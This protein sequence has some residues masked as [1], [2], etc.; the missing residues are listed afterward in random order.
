M[1]EAVNVREGAT[2]YRMKACDISQGGLKVE[3]DTPL[4]SGSHVVV[5]H[6][7]DRAATRRGAMDRRT[8]DGD[9][10]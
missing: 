7:G 4:P 2:T 5:K 10:L 8:A 1:S 6:R 9:Y 3:G